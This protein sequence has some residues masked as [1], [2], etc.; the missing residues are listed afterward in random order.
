L[1]RFIAICDE[2]NLTRAAA[3]EGIA[4]SAGSERMN[5]SR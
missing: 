1:R 5:D 4:A 2:Q 3:R